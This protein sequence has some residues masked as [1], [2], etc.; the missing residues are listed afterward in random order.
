MIFLDFKKKLFKGINSDTIKLEVHLEGKFPF[1]P[2]RILLS[3]TTSFP[4]L[5]DGRNLL[6]NI[7][8]KPWA[9]DITVLEIANLFPSFFTENHHN[10]GIGNFS[11]GQCISLNFWENREG[12]KT[13]LCQEIDPQNQKFSRERVLVLSHSMI[14]QLEMNPQYPGL[15]HLICYASLSTIITVKVS[16]SDNEKVT[17]E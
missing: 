5:S 8:K 9:E 3:T 12:M 14:L 15:G 11:F 6:A 1:Q 17:F 2:P 13:F 4:S 10:P 7:I 16:K